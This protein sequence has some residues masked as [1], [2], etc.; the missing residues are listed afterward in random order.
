MSSQFT[1]D[2]MTKKLGEILKP[3]EEK[4]DRTRWYKLT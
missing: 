2:N 3:Y 4:Y 1:L